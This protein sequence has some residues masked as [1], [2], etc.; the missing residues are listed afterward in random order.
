MPANMVFIALHMLLSKRK[1]VSCLEVCLR[2][3]THFALIAVYANSLLATSVLFLG[4]QD[5]LAW[6]C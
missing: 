3:L 1:H 5:L 2:W 6:I 4:M